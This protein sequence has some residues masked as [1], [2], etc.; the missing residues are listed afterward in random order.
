[1]EAAL[2]A[3]IIAEKMNTTPGIPNEGASICFGNQAQF[4]PLKY[5]NGLCIAIEKGA[6]KYLHKH[7][8]RR[9]TARELTLLRVTP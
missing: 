8:P 1:M 9:Y 3:G 6:A 7:M 4:H 2:R 5:L